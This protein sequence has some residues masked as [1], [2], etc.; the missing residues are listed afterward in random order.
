[1]TES[2]P[3]PDTELPP[4]VAAIQAGYTF[5]E[6]AIDLGVLMEDDAPVR[7]ASGSGSRC[8]C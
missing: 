7:Q 2:A 8:P 4:E 6:P 3:V 5:D 1:M